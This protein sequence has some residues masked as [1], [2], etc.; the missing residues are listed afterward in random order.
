MN[1]KFRRHFKLS[2]SQLNRFSLWLLIVPAV[3]IAGRAL[4][5]VPNWSSEHLLGPR[6]SVVTLTNVVN[7]LCTSVQCYRASG[8]SA[9]LHGIYLVYTCGCMQEEKQAEDLL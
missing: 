2:I 5:N 3:R 7:L 1:P 6:V 4:E 8:A 9:N